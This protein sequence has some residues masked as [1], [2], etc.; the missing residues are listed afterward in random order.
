MR[1]A[2]LLA[3]FMALICSV[4]CSTSTTSPT[5]PAP[6]PA[7][8]LAGPT[9]SPPTAPAAETAA[10]AKV[11][12]PGTYTETIP[13]G[14]IN[15]QYIIHVPSGY[16]GTRALPLVF[17]LHGI[18]GTDKGMVAG[19]GMVQQADQAGFFAVFPM[20]TGSPTG[21][22][23]VI[24]PQPITTV[25]DLGFF[26]D[27]IARFESRLHVDPKRIY[28]TGLSNGA[29]Q[30]YQLGAEI[31]N[32]LAAIAVVEGSI[33][34]RDGSTTH[35]IPQ[36]ASALPVLIIH[37]QKDTTA[38]YYGGPSAGQLHLNYFSVAEAV[39]FWTKS[40]GCAQPP[41]KK[42]LNGGAIVSEDYQSCAGGS[43]VLFYSIVNGVHEWPTL[44]N[45]AKFDGTA[46]IW[47]FFSQHSR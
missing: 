6:A 25:D 42:T 47:D 45:Q 39:S 28:V 17:V 34:T 46:A 38:P 5:V 22:N 40:D 32:T 3:C 30:A 23:D 13:S 14:G 12:P 43:E 18:G 44:E 41:T 29:F 20:G 16:D 35:V 31:P 27:M 19:T 36:P 4:A 2:R 24:F 10:L 37:G 7:P 11:V 15:R 33:G 1:R 8:T 26:K 21:W 9:A